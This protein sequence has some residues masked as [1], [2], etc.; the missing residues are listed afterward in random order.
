MAAPFVRYLARRLAFAAL[1]VFL[2]SSASLLLARL[3]PGDAARE[4]AG[5]N[6]DEQTV[7]RIRAR[8][9]LD[10]PILAQYASWVSRAARLDFGTSYSYGTRVGP[11]VRQRAG[12]T[13][14]LAAAA[15]LTAT[16]LGIPLGVVTG[17]RRGAI[18]LVI[19]TCSVL[20]LSLPPL[21]TS[22]LL[23][24]LAART[25]ILPV[26]GMSSLDAGGG[27]ADLLRYLPV[28]VLSLALPLA[29][30]FERMQSQAMRD[31]LAEPCIRAARARGVPPRRLV[32]R[33]AFRLSG[34]SVASVYGLL[35]GTLFSGSFI[36]E[37]VTAWPGL[38]RLM[39]DALR[40]RDVYLVAG[41]AAAGAA[42]LAVGSVVSDV[43]VAAIDPR[44]RTDADRA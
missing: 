33:D 23:V 2:V 15:L 24:F 17:S 32:W 1:L 44:V 31:A 42:F 13:A 3:A 12:N 9:G 8:L 20:L 7:A 38:G 40:T 28:P 14:I 22:L 4:I 37:N 30:M 18:A 39:F 16:L 27:P 29:A 11:I 10:R 36:V 43:A 26:G 21:L 19:R 34:R 35:V 41:V 25:Q 6:A 5:V